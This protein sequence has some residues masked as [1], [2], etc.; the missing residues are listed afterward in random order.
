MSGSERKYRQLDGSVEE[1]GL[2]DQTA[3]V[4]WDEGRP[5]PTLDA[6][7]YHGL[8]GEIVRAIALD[9]EADPA[10]LLFSLL[11]G[12][13]NIAGRQPAAFV[14]ADAHP[15][16]LFVAIVGETSS[17]AKGTSWAA[18]L[19][20]LRAA[21]ERWLTTRIRNGFGSGEAIIADVA[22][23]GDEAP[24][25]RLFVLEPEFSRLLAINARDGSTQSMV[26]R[27]AWDGG[28]LAVR[29]SKDRVIA[30]GAH[31]SIVGHVTPDELRA[32]LTEADVAGGFANRF[33][34]V[35]VRRSRKI[36]R[37]RPLQDSVAGGFGGRIAAALAKASLARIA[38]W[39]ADAEPLWDA[40]YLHEPDRDGLVGALTA[41]A[42][43]QK[44]RLAVA[45]ALLDGS[46]IIRPEHLAAAEAAWRYCAASAEHLFG[47][48]RGDHVQDRLLDELRRVYPAGLTLSEQD[49]LFSKNLRS[50]RLKAAREALEGRRLIVSKRVESG[51][52][53][54][55]PSYVSYAVPRASL[56]A[57]STGKRGT[58]GYEAVTPCYPVDSVG[59]SEFAER[60]GPKANATRQ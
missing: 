28:T 40:L 43:P 11:A 44:L 30:E 54:G 56:P 51:E 49:A 41:R 31:V 22:G 57:E 18:V 58:T 14:H 46:A 27:A 26:L 7:A 23:T 53:G 8:A 36:P 38:T 48:L 1:R 50:G 12:V 34:L 24:D 9:T 29:R 15:A 39:S 13:G 35:C 6:A 33:L 59:E 2:V 47:G 19:P 45:Y 55:R 20:V 10:A 42:H 60:P 25:T 21:D 3:P 16:R 17:G 5:W 52:Q 4:E 37:P 32:R